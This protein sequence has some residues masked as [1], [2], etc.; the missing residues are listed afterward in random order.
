[1]WTPDEYRRRG[2]WLYIVF[3]SLAGAPVVYGLTKNWRIVLAVEIVVIAGGCA[4][5]YGFHTLGRK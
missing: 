1:M 2:K 5:E 3:A 4:G